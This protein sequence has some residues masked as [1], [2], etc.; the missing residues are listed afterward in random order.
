MRLHGHQNDPD[1]RT[2]DSEIFVQ[3]LEETVAATQPGTPVPNLSRIDGVDASGTIHCTVDLAGALLDLQ[4]DPGWW[5][6]LGPERVAAGVLEALEHAR[7]KVVVAVM[8]L[9]RHG[10]QAQP[11]PGPDFAAQVAGPPIDVP[12]LDSPDFERTIEA[13]IARGFAVL[14]AARRLRQRLD[15]PQ[16]R[17]VSGPRGLFRVVVVGTAVQGAE[18]D[19][20]RLGPYGGNQLADD[21]RPALQ[22][23]YDYSRLTHLRGI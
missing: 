5:S 14:E 8:A 16:R 10:H 15:D 11:A 12:H 7:T 21:A 1:A 18:V 23:A 6:A 20:D 9:N 4:I 17:I 2:Q 19:Q 13:K 3:N 22:E